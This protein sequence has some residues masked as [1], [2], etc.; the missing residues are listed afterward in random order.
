MKIINKI[1]FFMK[2]LTLKEKQY[3]ELLFKSKCYDGMISCIYISKETE[4]ID[5]KRGKGDYT[6]YK[7]TNVVNYICSINIVEMLKAGGFV[8]DKSIQW[9]ITT[10]DNSK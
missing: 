8:F 1:K 10:D 3:N 6:V 2:K 7:F 4:T 5:I 9:N